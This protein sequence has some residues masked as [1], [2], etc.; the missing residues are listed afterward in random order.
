MPGRRVAF[1]VAVMIVGLAGIV[2]SA[3]PEAARVAV[4]D[5]AVVM[6]GYKRADKDLSAI[7]GASAE[8]ARTTRLAWGLP[9][10]AI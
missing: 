8:D 4:V 5:M 10:R 1:V 7:R 6:K 2:R 9:I 3:E